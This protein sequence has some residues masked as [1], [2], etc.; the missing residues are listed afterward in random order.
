MLLF[1]YK[2]R[3]F[4]HSIT[5]QKYFWPEQANDPGDRNDESAMAESSGM[6]MEPPGCMWVGAPMAS[7]RLSVVPVQPTEAQLNRACPAPALIAA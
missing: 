4:L 1:V 2:R 7:S 3:Y 5:A 6:K